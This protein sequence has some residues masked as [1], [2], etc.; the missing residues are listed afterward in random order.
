MALP[1]RRKFL[2]GAAATV[3]GLLMS[4][5]SWAT[6]PEKVPGSSPDNTAAKFDLMAEIKKYRKIDSHAHVYFNSPD[7]DEVVDIADRL[8]IE[9]LAISR[10]MVPGGKG[11]PKEFTEANNLVLRA[12][13]KHPARF[14]PQMTLNPQYKK[15]SLEEIQRCV[16]EGMIGLKLYNHVK[17]NDPLFYPIIEKFIDLKMVILMHMGI[18]KAR[19]NYDSREPVN[20]SIPSDIAEAARRYPEATFQLA[21]LGGGIDWEDA[22][23]TVQGIPNIYVDLSGSNNEG[24]IVE[25]AMKYIGEDRLLFACDNSFYQGVGHIIAGNLTESQRRKIFFENYNN[26]LKKI[27]RNVN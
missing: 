18:G 2:T 1:N 3:S 19:I 5:E 14:L 15:E 20:V 13:K 10:P 9:K 25:C 26:L 6:V 23:K 12:F 27:G 4:R 7:G 17:M 8:F 24:R 16:D 21:H 11:D 22:C